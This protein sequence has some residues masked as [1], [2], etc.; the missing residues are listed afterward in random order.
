MK[1]LALIM[2]FASGTLLL[3]ACGAPVTLS[4]PGLAAD[5]QNAYLASGSLVYAVRLSD[6]ARLWQYPERTGPQ[7]FYSNP[8][9]TPDGHVL[10]G[11]AGT[12]YGLV[13]LD[14]AT[15]QPT[16]AAPFVASN[17]W[18][19][20]PLVVGETIYAPNHNGTLYALE[21]A[22]GTLQWS[23]P[24][25]N[26][27]WGAP[28]SNGKLVFVN[29]LDHYVYAVDPQTRSVV[30]KLNLGGSAPNAA[31]LSSDGNTLFVGSFARKVL[32]V[33]A[34]SGAVR[35]TTDVKDWVWGAPAVDG[36]SVYAADIKG[37]I[38]SL[39]ATHGKNAWPDLQPDGPITGSP[40]VL[41]DG[42]LVATESGTIFA[43]DRTGGKAWDAIIGGKIYTTPVASGEMITLAPMDADFLLAAISRD[44][45]LLWKF[46]G[47]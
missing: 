19:A 3:S 18:V 32:A 29:S 9:V 24:L 20:P 5:A 33:D 12:D 30:W 1:R 42:M 15:G 37:H 11:S 45:K 22:T 23:L 2:L 4:W 44:G 35:W 47:K 7:I 46:T 13:S 39:G 34:A 16:W 25:G 6:G 21:L 17:Y 26:L 40:L 38:Y 36:D 14:P 27:L 31:S 10:V 8:V 41:A 43:F 28:V